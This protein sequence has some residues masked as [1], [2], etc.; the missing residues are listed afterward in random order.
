MK[1]RPEI[2]LFL[3]SSLDG[4]ISTGDTDAM[5]FDRDLTKVKGVKEGLH[6]YYELEQKT[7]LFSLNS[8]RV[9]S[10]MGVNR[11]KWT[12][13]P[14][15]VSFIVIDNKPHLSMKELAYLA[16]K[17]KKVFIVTTSKQ[18]PVFS[19]K[20]PN[21]IALFYKLKIDLKDM[22][23]KLKEEYGIHRITLQT[24]GTLNAE[25]VRMGLVDHIS[26]VVAPIMVGGRN[27]SSVM[28]GESLHRP[29]ELS[30][31]KALKLRGVKKLKNSY[32]HVRYDVMP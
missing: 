27:T 30:K 17:S 29:S 24:G 3:L 1:S 23:Q 4:K 18:H 31:L 22:M 8:G 2:T 16:K 12:K 5:D 28:D 7:D 15:P 20:Y 11:M 10:K 14:L 13:P 32:L 26:I 19:K 6:Q 9:F 21:I 25:F